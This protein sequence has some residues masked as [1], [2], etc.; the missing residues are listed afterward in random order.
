MRWVTILIH[1]NICDVTTVYCAIF[2]TI[3]HLSA[4]HCHSFP[5]QVYGLL[6]ITTPCTGA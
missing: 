2:C 5:Q 1:L 6:P 4:T 3:T